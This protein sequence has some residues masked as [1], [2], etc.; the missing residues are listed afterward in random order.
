MRREVTKRVTFSRHAREQIEER[1]LSAE[2]VMQAVENPEQVVTRGSRQIGQRRVRDAEK[3]YLL[4]VV[5]EE[6]GDRITVVT[7]YRTSKISKYWR[8]E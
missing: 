6:H 7:V 8:Q 4:R 1:G 5:Y 3:E 2:V